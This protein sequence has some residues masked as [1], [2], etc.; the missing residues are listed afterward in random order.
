LHYPQQTP[1]PLCEAL[2]GWGS[3]E[4]RK[5]LSCF[6]PYPCLLHMFRTVLDYALPS[7]RVPTSSVSVNRPPNLLAVLKQCT[8]HVARWP[9]HVLVRC[10]SDG[11]EADH[12]IGRRGDAVALLMTTPPPRGAVGNGQL[13]EEGGGG[14]QSDRTHWR[15]H[16]HEP[17]AWPFRQPSQKDQ[18]RQTECRYNPLLLRRKRPRANLPTQRKNRGD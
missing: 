7:A 13:A 2:G 9:S 18:S 3:S 1:P 16:L 14:R 17:T 8:Q 10:D 4:E 15:S 5:R 11:G 6:E 12:T